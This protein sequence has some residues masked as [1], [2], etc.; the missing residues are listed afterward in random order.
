MKLADRHLAEG[1][2]PC[3]YIGRR[4]YR[5]P[6]GSEGVSR[7]YYAEWSFNGRRDYEALKTKNR[8]AALRKAHEIARRIQ[9]GEAKPI[10]AQLTIT[11]MVEQFLAAKGN[12]DLAPK[13]ITKYTNDLNRLLD[14]AQL[15]QSRVRL[16]S[17]FDSPQLWSFGKHL[18]EMGD[19]LK[20]RYTRLTIVKQAFKW[21][22]EHSL[23]S[24]YP[25][26][27]VRL[28][29]P[30]SSQQPCFTPVQI[31]KLLNHADPLHEG[32]A[33]A[34]MAYAGLRVGEVRD[35]RWSNVMLDAGDHGMLEIRHGGSRD[36]T[37]NQ[38]TRHIPI[39][40]EL[41]ICLNT[42]P[43]DFERVF[44]ARP[45]ARYPEGGRPVSP[46]KLLRSLK[47]LCKRVEFV[48]P[49]QYKLHTFRHTFASMCARN[50]ISHKYALEW[51]GH[52]SSKILDI[53]YKMF[54]DVSQQAMATIDY[55][56]DMEGRAVVTEAA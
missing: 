20:T 52:S 1:T 5:R 48:E 46:D 15:R 21:A 12:E 29:A 24:E 49:Q 37:K 43:K 36:S 55:P 35:L 34:I 41:R 44:T 32:A 6:D 22:Y 13:T 39:H 11:E 18:T 56:I 54:D 27:K 10:P 30:P 33:F 51:M 50:N 3:I 26:R 4:T 19:A 53:Y 38:S 14:W 31:A 42:L 2:E 16:A 40:S 28:K 8:N 17:T 9:N 45:S 47:R 23:L 7:N 25:L